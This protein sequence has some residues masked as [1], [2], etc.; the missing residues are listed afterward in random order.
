MKR[1]VR[2]PEF[3]LVPSASAVSCIWAT[4]DTCMADLPFVHWEFVWFGL[5]IKFQKMHG[6]Q[7]TSHHQMA[8]NELKSHFLDQQRVHL[9]NITT[10]SADCTPQ[11]RAHLPQ[12]PIVKE[13]E[14]LRPSLGLPLRQQ[15]VLA[16]ANGELP[17]S[18]DHQEKCNL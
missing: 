14:A 7:C 16:K 8:Q 10:T 17:W 4:S 13:L 1:E 18:L 5:I 15:R 3:V 6:P 11:P 9:S 12:E 2:P